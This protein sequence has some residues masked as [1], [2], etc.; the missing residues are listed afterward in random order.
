MYQV[1]ES[2]LQK[3][4]TEVK[5]MESRFKVVKFCHIPRERNARANEPS[6]LAIMQ[7]REIIDLLY[8]RHEKNP[9]TS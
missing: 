4:L 6:K 7:T 3:Y 5:A 9:I 2:L 8:S 1:E